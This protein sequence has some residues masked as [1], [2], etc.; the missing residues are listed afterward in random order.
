MKRLNY[1]SL[2]LLVTLSSCIGTEEVEDQIIQISVGVP[3][4]VP[5]VN[6]VVSKVEGQELNLTINALNDKGHLFT[7]GGS[8]FSADQSIVSIDETGKAVAAGLGSTTITAFAFGMESEPI[9][10]TVVSDDT[11][12][13][14]I[15]ITADSSRV[16]V[17]NQL[18]LRARALNVIGNEIAGVEIT[19]LS[20][21]E[22]VATVDSEGLLTGVSTGV[23]NI[24]ASSNPISA[25]F[26]V[27]VGNTQMRQGFFED[28]NGYNTSG[29]VSIAM[30]GE[31]LEVHLAEDFST[32]R[33]PGLYLYLSNNRTMVN[34][35]V[36]LGK[37]I[38]TSGASSYT[39]PTGISIDD[40]DYV[41]IYCKPF[42]AGFGTSLLDN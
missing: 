20:S 9:R 8:W 37:L 16:E 36:E 26:Q 7:T 22:N 15:E 27:T 18:Q 31:N 34:G 13:A 24:E 14:L 42:G 12:V 39:A 29:G 40:F 30:V 21:D 32:S 33:G 38:S 11:S 17:G 5:L 41:I 28:L 6:N 10:F 2:I 4:E 25:T 23:V 35:G 19:W 1:F 3:E